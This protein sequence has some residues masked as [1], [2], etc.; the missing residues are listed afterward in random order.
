MARKH[1]AIRFSGPRC[2]E[3]RE[4]PPC[5]PKSCSRPER[6]ERYAREYSAR[7][8]AELLVDLEM[9]CGVDG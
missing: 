6:I 1:L 9:K 7:T 8:L 4:R 5:D 3:C 2:P